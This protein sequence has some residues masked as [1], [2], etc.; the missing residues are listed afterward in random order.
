MFNV[1]VNY[2]TSAEELRILKQTTG[3]YEAE[4]KTALT[5]KQILALQEV[6]R[7]VPVAEHVFIYARDLV[8][9]TRPKEPDAPDFIREYISWGA[10]P[11]AGQYLILGAKAM[12]ILHGRFHVT[13]D[14]IRGVAHPVLRHRMV[15]TFHADSEGVATDDVV[16]ML[17]DRVPVA[18]QARAAE[19]AMG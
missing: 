12:A 4:L 18:L 19:T 16:Q 17:L 2:P 14:D 13:T 1:V 7:K 3:G 10:G 8:R 5:G 6:V 15:T 9:A 11:R